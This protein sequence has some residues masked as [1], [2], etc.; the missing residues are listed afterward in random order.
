MNKFF[1]WCNYYFCQLSSNTVRFL[2]VEFADDMKK[3]QG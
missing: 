1:I 3:E 2:V